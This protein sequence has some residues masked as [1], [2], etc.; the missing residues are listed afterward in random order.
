MKTVLCSLWMALLLGARLL[1]AQDMF[2]SSVDRYAA[3]AGTV[4]KISGGGFPTAADGVTVYFGA[5]AGEVVSHTAFLLSVKVPPHA[6]YG[7]ISVLDKMLGL[8]VV[9][10]TPFLLSHGGDTLRKSETSDPMGY[11]SSDNYP[12]YDICTCDFDNDGR[13]DVAV[14]HYAPTDIIDFWRFR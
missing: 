11:L 7:H 2:I 6:T 8:S 10:P 14:S 1:F 4:I 13:M 5:A 3:P 9:S 12:M